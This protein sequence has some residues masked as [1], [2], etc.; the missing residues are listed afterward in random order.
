MQIWGCRILLNS[1]VFEMYA[2]CSP[3]LLYKN[4]YFVD[5]FLKTENFRLL[6]VHLKCYIVMY[7]YYDNYLTYSSFTDI[8]I[9]TGLF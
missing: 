8:I 2:E 1:A 3:Q 9:L 4:D 6:P 7:S 5:A